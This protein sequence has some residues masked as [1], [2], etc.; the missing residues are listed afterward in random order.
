MEDLYGKISRNRGFFCEREARKIVSEVKAVSSKEQELFWVR[1]TLWHDWFVII[2][3]LWCVGKRVISKSVKETIDTCC[4]KLYFYFLRFSEIFHSDFDGAADSWNIWT[5]PLQFDLALDDF[6][7][8]LG[9]TYGAVLN[10]P[11]QDRRSPR[12]MRSCTFQINA[13]ILK[14]IFYPK[15]TLEYVTSS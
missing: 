15:L 5:K 12:Q 1:N 6:Q 11:E 2:S 4:L 8:H 3:N 10:H 9:S 7:I 13:L 14:I